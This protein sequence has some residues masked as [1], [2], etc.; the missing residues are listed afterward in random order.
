MKYHFFVF[1]AV[2]TAS[3]TAQESADQLT[4]PF[5]DATRP[6]VVRVNLI[7]GSIAVRAYDGNDLI[8]E[9]DSEPNQRRSN[10]EI[11]GLRRIDI[12][13]PGLQVAE[14]DNTIRITADTHSRAVELRMQV[15]RNTSLQLRSI[16]AGRISVEGVDGELD[17][18]TTNGSVILNDVSGTVIAHTLNGKLT[19]R[20][21]RA[22]PDKPM[23]FSTLNGDVDVSLPPD[24]KARLKLKSDNGDVYSDFD[25]VTQRSTNTTPT[26]TVDHKGRRIA[27]DRAVYG[28]INGGG[29][30]VSFT[31]LNGK[32]LIRKNK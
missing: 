13:R 14:Q 9:S 24:M 16:N 7:H 22:A 25:I 19:V 1:I 28:T 31:T 27:M 5:S 15:P 4:V 20:L 11:D 10:R 2:L 21:S 26:S 8:I 3:G 30:E 18:N 17:V 12:H 32:I 6:R 29:P 23:S